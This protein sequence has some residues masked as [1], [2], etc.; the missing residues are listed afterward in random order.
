[1]GHYVRY[2]HAQLVSLHIQCSQ[3]HGRPQ[4]S[5][6]DLFELFINCYVGLYSNIM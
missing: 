4:T 5:E 3:L 1:M 6:L 2:L